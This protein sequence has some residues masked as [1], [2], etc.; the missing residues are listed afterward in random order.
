M[1]DVKSDEFW[2]SVYQLREEVSAIAQK[3]SK[4]EESAAKTASSEEL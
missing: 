4:N 3:E 1:T 2:A